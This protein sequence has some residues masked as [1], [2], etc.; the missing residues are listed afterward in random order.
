MVKSKVRTLLLASVM[1]ML[2]TVMIVGGSYA[3]WSGNV[4]VSN[5][6]QAGSLKVELYRTSLTKLT[7]GEDGYLKSDTDDNP[8]N[9]SDTNTETNNVFGIADDEKVVPGASYEATMK[10]VN[11]G[12]VAFTY[13][14][15]IELKELTDNNRALAN[16]LKVYVDDVDKGALSS[17]IGDNNT[18]VISTDLTVKANEN[19]SEF[20]IKI[21]F[22]NNTDN[23]TNNAAQKQEVS[24]DLIINATQT[25]QKTSQ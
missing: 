23:T 9:F 16:Q 1:I 25:T 19:T 8:I 5:H 7:L 10:L 12:S 6:L 22:V 3:L 15:I 17:F 18:A 14:I 13:D 11:S 20:T 24:F 4:T 2:C 21:E